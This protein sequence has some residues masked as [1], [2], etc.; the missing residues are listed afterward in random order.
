MQY[1]LSWYS[2]S[3]D[4]HRSKNKKKK[5]DKK[6]NSEKYD[7]INYYK[8]SEKPIEVSSKDFDSYDPKFNYKTDPR[9]VYN[10]KIFI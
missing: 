6:R 10:T 9:F 2:M 4:Q 3:E 7:D 1:I 8:S 5:K